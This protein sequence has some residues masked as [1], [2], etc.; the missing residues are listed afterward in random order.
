MNRTQ[1]KAR[2]VLVSIITHKQ[3]DPVVMRNVKAWRVDKARAEYVHRDDAKQFN[4]VLR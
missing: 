4:Q 3:K 1:Q 2:A